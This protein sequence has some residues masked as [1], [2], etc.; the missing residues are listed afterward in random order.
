MCR[1]CHHYGLRQRRLATAVAAFMPQALQAG[2]GGS[3]AHATGFASRSR[4][5]H[6][7]RHR[8]F[9]PST[10]AA[11]PTPQATAA[12][13]GGSA[14]H[15]A[16]NSGRPRRQH[17]SYH[18]LCR[19]APHRQCRPRHKQQQPSTAAAPLTPQAFQSIHIGSATPAASNT[20]VGVTAIVGSAAS[21][22]GPP[23]TPRSKS[24]HRHVQ[25][26]CA[27]QRV[28]QTISSPKR[29]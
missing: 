7:S 2:H 17:R 4:R 18:R 1:R 25:L 27:R 23:L 15:A 3:G 22:T 11:S 26:P 12:V 9:R 5:Q 21:T 13:H 6:R 16:S 24:K 10:A 28:P 20:T 14:A 8:H 29:R 19:L